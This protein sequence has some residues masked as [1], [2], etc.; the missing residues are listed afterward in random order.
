[1]NLTF[2]T[3]GE[4]SQ[5]RCVK[6]S[7]VLVVVPSNQ[8]C[9]NPAAHKESL[10]EVQYKLVSSIKASKVVGQ[11]GYSR[12]RQV[13]SLDQ[14]VIGY[15][16]CN[17]LPFINLTVQYVDIKTYIEQKS[18]KLEVHHSDAPIGFKENGEMAGL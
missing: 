18:W 8:H 12:R 14:I 10:K 7:K 17:K 16:N 3:T 5:G 15:L 1:M 6:V 11:A 13:S 9:Q 4:K 2:S